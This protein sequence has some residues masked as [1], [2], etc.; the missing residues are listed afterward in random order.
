MEDNPIPLKK[1]S[2]IESFN[3]L[4]TV[5][6]AK[7]TNWSLPE[8]WSIMPGTA[9]KEIP[10]SD[11]RDEVQAEK[12]LELV[13]SFV[14]T[15]L[16]TFRIFTLGSIKHSL[17]LIV[18]HTV[19]LK[20]QHYTDSSYIATLLVVTI[21][22]LLMLANLYMIFCNQKWTS[23]P[24]TNYGR[25]GI[26]ILLVC[27]LIYSFSYSPGLPL[28]F[29]VIIMRCLSV[30]PVVEDKHRI[31]SKALVIIS[32][33]GLFTNACVQQGTIHPTTN[34]YVVSILAFVFSHLLG[35]VL[36]AGWHRRCKRAL[37]LLNCLCEVSIKQLVNYIHMCN[38]P[39]FMIV[40][41][42]ETDGNLSFVRKKSKPVKIREYAKMSMPE[43][44]VATN[45]GQLHEPP[46]ITQ[47]DR[48]AAD[49]AQ[50]RELLHAEGQPQEADQHE[51]LH[52]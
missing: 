46:A 50:R 40:I 41:D 1:R 19:M 2:L 12:A 31:A 51:L 24:W 26:H 45:L 28:F 20:E 11:S 14:E 42:Q 32:D 27:L 23:K 5:L 25:Y 10:P 22:T 17:I 16:P 9:P 43:E 21:S 38:I 33:I 37:E 7:L 47:Q 44:V 35:G 15:A 36:D 3:R 8:R 29:K 39:N 4:T 30:V 48:A 52:F 34:T 18:A 13:A 6:S 49:P